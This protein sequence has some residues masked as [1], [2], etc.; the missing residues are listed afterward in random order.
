[1][2][3]RVA[4]L[5]HRRKG[6]QVDPPKQSDRR[7]LRQDLAEPVRCIARKAGW[8]QLPVPPDLQEGNGVCKADMQPYEEQQLFCR[9]R[10]R[11]EQLASP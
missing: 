4:S 9:S 2:G 11:L 8:V 10:G 7:P 3:D 1:M 5:E 6:P